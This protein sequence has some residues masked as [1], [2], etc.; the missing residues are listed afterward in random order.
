M[1][2]FICDLVVQ[3]LPKYFGQTWANSFAYQ[4]L[5][6]VGNTYL[7]SS[8]MLS[9]SC[10]ALAN[11]LTYYSGIL[12]GWYHSSIPCLPRSLCLAGQHG[13]H[14]S[15][16][17]LPFLKRQHTRPGTFQHVVEGWKDEGF[18]GGLRCDVCLCEQRLKSLTVRIVLISHGSAR[19]S[20]GFLT[21]CSSV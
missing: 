17:V 6:G 12:I 1:G 2:R 9:N 14:G 10:S 20:S 8:R 4:Y 15:Q 5:L 21:T 3:Y 7:V 19:T 13:H 16:S 18:L 11:L